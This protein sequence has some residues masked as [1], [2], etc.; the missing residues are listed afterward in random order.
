[1]EGEGM[2]EWK[3]VLYFITIDLDVLLSLA[4]QSS[5]LWNRCIVDF[6]Q[7]EKYLE[8]YRIHL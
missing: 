3:L 1:M 4:K 5:E 2:N 7:A 6:Q 8:M